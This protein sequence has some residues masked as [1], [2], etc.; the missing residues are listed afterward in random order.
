MG[1]SKLDNSTRYVGGLSLTE[2]LH[3]A[4]KTYYVDTCFGELHASIQLFSFLRVSPAF[5]Y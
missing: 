2:I 3:D 4:D 1:E 5:E